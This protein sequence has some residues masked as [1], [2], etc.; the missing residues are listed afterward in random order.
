MLHLRV[1][2]DIADRNG[3][4]RVVGTPGFDNTV[5]YIEGQLKSKTN[6]NVFREEFPTPVQVKNSPI[7]IST[8]QG[9]DKKYIYQ[10]DFFKIARSRATNF[11]TSIR[12]TEVPNGGCE[13]NDWLSATPHPAT[14]SVVIVAYD[15]KC[16][17]IATSTVAQ[18]Y[19]ISGLLIFDSVA[20]TTDPDTAEVAW[21]TIFPALF[22]SHALGEQM[23]KATRSPLLPKPSVRISIPL[24]DVSTVLIPSTNLC[25]DTPTGNRTE[26]IIV[27]GHSDS[28]ADG[29]G[30][31]DNGT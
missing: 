16:S 19:N 5:T 12:L 10:T 6:F 1:L 8:I 4:T 14:D 28:V 15:K 3:N 27:G 25:A 18:K 21:S 20:N 2:Q 13:D 9:A 24:S 26:T 31:N 17:M 22:L 30:L 23:I 7:L 29:P 11:S